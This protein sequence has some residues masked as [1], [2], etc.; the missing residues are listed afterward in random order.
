MARI[1]FQSIDAELAF[2][3][4]LIEKAPVFM[5][6][7][8]LDDPA[9][10]L[11]NHNAW[12]NRFAREFIGYQQEEIESL[13]LQ[14]FLETMHPDDLEI[15]SDAIAKFDHQSN[16]LFGGLVRLKPKGNSEFHWCI[17]TIVVLEEKDGIP[18]RFLVIAHQMDHLKDTQS[19]IVDLIKENLQLRN[20]I[21]INTLT[22]REKQIMRLIS[23]SSTDKEIAASLHISIK[24]AKTH[25]HNIHRK[26]NLKNAASLVRFALE[27]GLN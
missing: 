8:Q 26:L 19:Q 24:T 5:S 27:N 21:L 3:R 2:L 1:I 14:F 16:Q 13:G 20:T 15:I 25:R 18:W 9:D 22:R 7:N 10:P 11:T 4:N 17:G 23:G 12:M 6:I